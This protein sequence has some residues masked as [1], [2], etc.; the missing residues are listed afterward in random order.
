MKP[1]ALFNGLTGITAV[2]SVLIGALTS[3]DAA[4]YIIRVDDKL[5]IRVF[6]FPELTGEYTV[7]TYGTIAL[8]P[9]GKIVVSGLTTHE[10]AKQIANRFIE[11]GISGTPGATVEILQS[12]PIYVLGDVQKPGEYPFRNGVTVLQ[13]ISLAG[14]WFRTIDPGLLRLD[15]DVIKIRGDMRNL[16]SRYDRLIAER[17]RLNAE[18]ALTSDI[19]FPIELTQKAASD[20]TVARLLDEERTFLHGNIES[21]N[22]QLESLEK[23]R[24]LYQ[25]EVETISRQLRANESK[26]QSVAAELNEVKA[27]RA[28]GLTSL[29]RQTTLDRMQ[30]EV[31]MAAQGYYTLILR[32]Q[33]NITQTEQMIFDLKSR[34]QTKLNEELRQIQFDLEDVAEKIDTNESLM[35]EARLASSRFASGSVDLVEARTITVIRMQDGKAATIEAGEGTAL[36]PGDVL[37]VERSVVPTRVAATIARKRSHVSSTRNGD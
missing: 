10:I 6:Q 34:R 5:K 25:Q 19:A 4:D 29:N 36:L 1:S 23:T 35:A 16:V 37:K 14:G 11:S 3:V 8:P 13:A 31:E 24:T 22:T 26:S 12:Q 17:A 21:L 2:L 9:I 15:R 18:L 20:P 28:R 32:A 33:Q 27:M 30:A 7:N